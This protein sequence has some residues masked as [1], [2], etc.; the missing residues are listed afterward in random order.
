MLVNNLIN[1][2][3]VNSNILYVSIIKYLGISK[4]A[5]QSAEK[6]IHFN[7]F[8]FMESIVKYFEILSKHSMVSFQ[9]LALN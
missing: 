2:F 3:E 7:P 8:F 5:L 6:K 1:I 4:I 9:I